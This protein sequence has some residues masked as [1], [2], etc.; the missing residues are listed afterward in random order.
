MHINV[1][2]VELYYK[3]S[4]QGSPVLLLHGNSEDHGIFKVL[5]K[6]LS[7]DHTVY[8]IDSRDHGR[9]SKVHHLNY[10]DKMNDIAEFIEVLGIEKPILYGFSDGGIIGLLLAIHH[11]DVL[12]KLIISGVNTN[13][14]GLKS[15]PIFLIKLHYFLTRSNKMK[16]MLTQ[17]NITPA[18]LGKIVTPTL[19][20]AGSK[21]FVKEEH[22]VAL[23]K[24]IPNSELRILS[25]ET[26][27]SYVINSKKL[28]GIIKTF[29]GE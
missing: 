19:V 16:L 2:N 28:Y 20:L 6:K 17:P 29:L 8:A 12:D 23:A 24:N 15:F 7:A 21:D 26:H 25:G 9:S 10:I 14:D 13:P 18:E 3:V 1:N 22:T 5:S 11:P 4:G 27:G